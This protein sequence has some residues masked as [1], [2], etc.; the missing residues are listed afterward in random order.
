VFGDVRDE[1]VRNRCDN[2]EWEQRDVKLFADA[3]ELVEAADPD[4]PLF[5]FV[6]L[7]STHFNY[8][9]PPSSAVHEPAWDGVAGLKATDAPGWLIKNRAK[10]AAHGVDARL[11]EFLTWFEARRG[12][13][14]LVVVTGDHGEEFRQK[15]HIGHGSAVVDEQIHVPLVVLGEGVPR[16]VYEQVVSHVDVVPTLFSLLGDTHPPASYSDGLPLFEAPRDRFVLATV[17]W[18]PRYALIGDDL[19]VTVYAGMAGMAV[20]DHDDRPLPDGEA[21]VAAHAGRILRTLRGEADVGGG[22]AAG[23]DARAGGSAAGARGS[24]AAP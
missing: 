23:A 19:K 4:A 7:F 16:G 10:N 14:P 11:D 18:E 1:D 8:F 5:A 2:K 17:G 20:T 9:Y 15:G 24:A 21:R 6:F 3:R 13:K 22:A 12:R